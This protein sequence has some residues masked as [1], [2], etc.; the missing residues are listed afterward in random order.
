MQNGKRSGNPSVAVILGI[1]IVALIFIAL[2]TRH[3]GRHKHQAKLVK[4]KNHKIY[5]ENDDGSTY[6]FVGTGGGDAPDIDLPKA[7]SSS[8][9]LPP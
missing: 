3:Q 4:T 1:I 7:G 8:F 2:V 9:R 5:V 6:T